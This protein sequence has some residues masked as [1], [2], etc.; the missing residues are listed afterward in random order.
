MV[1]YTF[2][3]NITSADALSKTASEAPA[4]SIWT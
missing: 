3:V 2:V 1:Q 4:D